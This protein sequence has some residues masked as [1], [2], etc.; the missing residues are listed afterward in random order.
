MPA[1]LI[2][3]TNLQLGR[4]PNTRIGL[5]DHVALRSGRRLKVRITR[6]PLQSDHENSFSRTRRVSPSTWSPTR[7]Q[8]RS[9]SGATGTSWHARHLLRQLS[10]CQSDGQLENDKL[11]IGVVRLGRSA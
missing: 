2:P 7:P 3:L 4:F 1:A 8:P 9:S 10:D 5:T 6:A 11:L